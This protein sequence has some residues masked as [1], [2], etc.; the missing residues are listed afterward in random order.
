MLRFGAIGLVIAVLLR[1]VLSL[2]FDSNCSDKRWAV[3]QLTMSGLLRVER[4]I[5]AGMREPGARDL[6]SLCHGH[7]DYWGNPLICAQSSTG[8]RGWIVYSVGANG[9]DDKTKEDDIIFRQGIKFYEQ[10]KPS[11][12]CSWF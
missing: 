9:L 8:Q 3:A 11:S 12:K 10:W 7:N 4:Q 5:L 2:E 1:A 6:A